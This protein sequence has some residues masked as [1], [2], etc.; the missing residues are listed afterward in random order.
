[1]K[2]R[3]GLL[4]VTLMLVSLFAIVG[5]GGDK[6]A[7]GGGSSALFSLLPAEASGVISVNFKKMAGMDF[8][9]KM[10]KEAEAKPE[11]AEGPFK[12]YQDF[13]DKTGIDPK[14]DIFAIAAGITGKIAPGSDTAVVAV[15]EMNVDQSKVLSI[16][17][18]KGAKYAEETYKDIAVYTFKDTKGKDQAFA[19]VKENIVGFGE[20]AML[21]KVIELSKGEGKSVLDNKKLMEQM[22]KL[23]S[24]SI[25][26]FAMEFPVEQKKLHDGGMFKADLSKAEA[27]LAEVDFSSGTWEG[28]LVLASDNPEGN[29]QLVTTINSM[30]G[31]AAIGG[32]EVA[33]L[34]KN[35]DIIAK[36]D[37]IVLKFSISEELAKKLQEMANKKKGMGGGM[38]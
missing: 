11:A 34:V 15:V 21:K 20:P 23:K 32:P 4:T 38:M 36:P 27:L 5:C 14:K 18:E 12:N 13:V 22:K 24:S 33:E 7:G 29:E 28:K 9:D 37:S 25:M 26:T 19:F 16:M 35:I 8:F 30:K 2:K 31:M 6:A 17:K 3:F 1:M 10:I